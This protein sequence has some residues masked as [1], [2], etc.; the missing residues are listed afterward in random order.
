[1]GAVD[2]SMTGGIG[3]PYRGWLAIQTRKQRHSQ[4]SSLGSTKSFRRYAY[5]PLSIAS[6]QARL[7][8][9][10]YRYINRW[11]EIVLVP[12]GEDLSHP[13]VPME[14]CLLYNEVCNVRPGDNVTLI[15]VPFN[16]LVRFVLLA[17]FVGLALPVSQQRRPDDDSVLHRA[18]SR[19]ARS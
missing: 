12:D 3:S 2:R 14:D 8:T 5:T 15:S 7:V 10:W 17:L 18:S 16:D 9:M 13:S 19:K 6:R 11:K 1:M 4:T